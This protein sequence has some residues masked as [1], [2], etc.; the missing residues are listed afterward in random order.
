MKFILRESPS[1]DWVTE[2]PELPTLMF[3]ID[4]IVDSMSDLQ[5]P[6]SGIGYAPVLEISK[7]VK[8]CI[9]DC[10]MEPDMVWFESGSGPPQFNNA[11][12]K[13]RLFCIC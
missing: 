13:N 1:G 2:N 6:V 7:W 5:F 4:S 8:H 9:G 10:K 12:S 11:K 3:P